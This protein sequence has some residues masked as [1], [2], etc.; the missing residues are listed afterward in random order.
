MDWSRFLK[1]SSRPLEIWDL[2]AL[3]GLRDLLNLKDFKTEGPHLILAEEGEIRK[4]R[5]FLELK[6]LADPCFELAPFSLSHRGFSESA[7]RKRRGWQAQA[8]HSRGVFLASPQSL[9][10]KTSLKRPL[11]LVKKGDRLSDMESI[12]YERRDPIA[13]AGDFSERGFLWDIFSPAYNR[14]LRVELTGDQV[15]SLHLLDPDWKKRAESLNQALLP[16]LREWDFSGEDVQ[17]LCRFLK[18]RGCEKKDLQALARRQIPSGFEILQNA[19]NTTCSLDWF[20]RPP[21]VWI[22]DPETLKDEYARLEEEFSL[23]PFLFE[24]IYL[25]WKRLEKET[26]IHLQ[27]GASFLPPFRSS[28]KGR[29][30]KSPSSLPPFRPSSNSREEKPS[31]SLPPFRSSSLKSREE[32][33]SSSLPPFRSSSNSREEK[34]PS[35]LPPFKSSESREGKSSTPSES[36]KEVW[37]YPC[38]RIGKN[39]KNFPNKW[40]P[41]V[42]VWVSSPHRREVPAFFRNKAVQKSSTPGDEDW[43]QKNIEAKSLFLQGALQESFISLPTGTAYLKPEDFEKKSPSLIRSGEVDSFESLRRRA[44]ALSFSELKEGDLVVHR[45]YGI[46]KFIGLQA[47]QKGGAD[48]IILLYKGGDRLLL[49]PFRIGELTK[50]AMYSSQNPHFLLDRLGDPRRFERKKERVKKHIQALTLELIEIYR[51]RRALSRPPFPPFSSALKEFAGEF[52]F[53]E[54]RGQIKAVSEIMGDMDRDRPMDRLLSADVGFGKTEVALRAVFRA[55]KG[56]FQVCWV[57]PTTA[58]SLQHYENFT[59]RFQN[60]P[61]KLGL[62][63]RFQNQKAK[64]DLLDQLRRGEIHFLIATHGVFRSRVTFKNPGLFVIDEEHRFGVSEKEKLHRFKKSVDI[65]S[66]SATPIPRTLNM[67]LSGIRDVSVI[68]EPPPRRRAVKILTKKWDPLL[69]QKA[70]DFEKERSGRILF[71]HNRIKTIREVERKLRSLLPHYRIAL[72]TGQMPSSRLERILVQF[73]KGEFDLLLST[74][75][76]ESGMDIPGADTLFVDHTPGLGLSRLHQ[77][78]GRVGRGEKQAYCYFLLPERGTVPETVRERLRLI[79]QY[80]DLGG[81]FHLALHD[82]EARGAGEIFGERQSG[83][84]SAV[85]PELYF[86]LLRESFSEKQEQPSLFPEPEVKLPL[87]AGIPPSYMPEPSLRL[88]YY[89][90]FS[91]ADSSEDLQA[92]IREMQHNFG[93]PPEEIQNLVSFLQI[94]RMGR[95][96]GLDHIKAEKDR[97]ILSFHENSAVSPEKL[98]QAIQEKNWR[99][100]KD[101][102]VTIPLNPAGPLC[103][104]IKAVLRGLEGSKSLGETARTDTKTTESSVSAKDDQD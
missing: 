85:G 102:S 61:F 63:N 4:L 60:R 87:S 2:D 90:S 75:I 65:L 89:K 79:E 17:K 44:R 22:Y 28:S 82:M 91:L 6:P 30:K 37:S 104:E 45:K 71:V 27:R 7:M 53:K 57:V 40:N 68:T 49:P 64:T 80:G 11:F 55:L 41:S 83:F 10:K 9:L 29:E 36:G 43:F 81:G 35:S 73:F 67:A 32:K 23:P 97:L 24:H 16:D 12:G 51:Q 93:P 84:L 25:P 21:L 18:E 96:M 33:S 3:S 56:G 34:F 31:S 66:L 8:R 26:C 48:F 13:Q 95:E 42:F 76:I 54:T 99:V 19:L 74:N 14:P 86:E 58:L 52:P 62:L 1:Q 38:Y 92:V 88:F 101:R 72:A 98:V 69:I 78:K 46:G 94:R 100:Q 39:L 77:L 15:T 47:L 103:E 59:A 5:S 20:S 70:C 50:Y